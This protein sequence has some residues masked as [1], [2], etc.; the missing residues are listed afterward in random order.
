MLLIV[1]HFLRQ[2]V[3]NFLGISRKVLRRAQH[4]KQRAVY[5]ICRAEVIIPAS[6]R[7]LLDFILIL[8]P[9]QNQHDILY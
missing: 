9:K 7:Y 4:P 5:Q 6:S 3:F 8:A 1:L 2:P